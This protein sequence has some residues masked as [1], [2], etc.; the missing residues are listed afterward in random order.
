MPLQLCIPDEKH[1]RIVGVYPALAGC[2]Y[3]L[4]QILEQRDTPPAHA[5]LHSN[6]TDG[7]E[8]MNKEWQRLMSHELRHLFV[9]AGEIV[10]RDLTALQPQVGDVLSLELTF[11]SAHIDAW[12]SAVNQARLI[13]GEL[14]AIQEA[15]FETQ[16]R[17]ADNPKDQAIMRIEV[18]DDLLNLFVEHEQ[19]DSV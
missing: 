18:L 15:D 10:A 3:E 17:A 16:E 12:V 4:P 7:D 11:P 2:L 9:S 14:F 5:R 8:K 1:I 19:Q 6:P 13:L